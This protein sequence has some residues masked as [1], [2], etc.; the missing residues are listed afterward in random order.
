MKAPSE[1]ARKEGRVDKE[2]A[3]EELESKLFILLW[4]FEENQR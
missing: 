3:G 4:V 2:K 1:K